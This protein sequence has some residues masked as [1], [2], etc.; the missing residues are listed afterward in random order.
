MSR[1]SEQGHPAAGYL[2][3]STSKQDKSLEDQRA[4]IQRYADQHG[5][6]IVRWYQDDAI[7]GDATE[8]R[9]QFLKMRGEVARGDFEFVLCWDQD[10]FGRFDSLDAGYW[11]YPFRQAGVKLVTVTDGPVDWDD[12]TS[13]MMYSFNQ[14][15]KHQYLRDLSRNVSRGL[16]RN[17]K[18]GYSC[19]QRAPYGYDR[20]LVDEQGNHRQR[21]RNGEQV[22][23]P[24]SWRVTFV[25]SDDPLKVETAK[26]LFETYASS[27]VGLRSMADQLNARGVPGPAGGPWYSASIRDILKNRKYV[28]DFAW[29]QRREGKYHRVVGDGVK[30]RDRREVTLAP[31]TSK[32]HA[33]D[34]PEEAWI[35]AEEAHEPLI[36]AET[37]RKVQEKL[38]RRR[39]NQ[40]KGKG[41]PYRTHTKANGDVYLLTGLVHCGHCGEK[42]HGTTSRRVKN[43]KTY[44]YP[45][46]LCSTYNR[47]G[48]HN[49]H[50]CGCHSV[51]QV[52]LVGALIDRLRED[53]MAGSRGHLEAILREKLT[54]RCQP[55]TGKVDAIRRRIAE[56]DRAIDRAADRLLSAPDNLMDVLA[57]KLSGMKKDRERLLMELRSAEIAC[58]PVDVE[59][60]ARARAERLWTLTEEI[61]EADPARVRELLR[62]LVSRIELHFEH[63]QRG[64]RLECPF[65]HGEIQ[66]NPAMFNCA[67]RGER[68]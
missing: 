47:C 5:Y 61:Q 49:P 51:H 37:F 43:G 17:A 11:I 23:K 38:E 59:S 63:V 60:E 31:N 57:P 66:L 15:G 12:F 30:E 44:S 26:W 7:S 1:K 32:P 24:R 19:G 62:N 54:D 8:C 28:G 22:A 65:S 55:D 14:E 67:N 40:P 35:L 2:R 33:I 46:Y 52:A 68:I 50:G 13:R 45:K 39:R 10:R 41:Y 4:E 34:N 53:V 36:D 20:M 48:K 27:D 25:P 42:M 56:I 6:R 29:A 64:K 16:I 21:V 3:R 58:G 18:N 9:T